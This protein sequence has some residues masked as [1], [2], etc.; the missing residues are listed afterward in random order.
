MTIEPTH[1]CFDDAIEYMALAFIEAPEWA[2]ERLTLVH[3]ICRIP[4][5]SVS[6]GSR[7]AHAWVED[8]DNV[9]QAGLIAGEKTYYAMPL[10]QHYALMRVERTTVYTME[11]TA[12]LPAGYCEPV[13]AELTRNAVRCG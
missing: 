1:T 3:A 12:A 11:A 7:F 4:D 13:Y 5:G 2:R 10:A 8:G 9:I 6:A